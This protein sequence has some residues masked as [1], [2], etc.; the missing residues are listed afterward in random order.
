MENQEILNLKK[1]LSTLE[2]ENKW[3]NDENLKLKKAITSIHNSKSWKITTPLRFVMQKISR[4]KWFLAQL[5][6]I[7]CFQKYTFNFNSINSKFQTSKKLASGRFEII[8][9]SKE[10]MAV[11]FHYEYAPEGKGVYLISIAPRSETQRQIINLP[12]GVHSIR[13]EPLNPKQDKISFSSFEL[14]QVGMLQFI[15]YKLTAKYGEHWLTIANL[16]SIIKT[17]T[18]KIK[19]H[20][21]RGLLNSSSGNDNYPL[22]VQQFDTLDDTE[23]RKQLVEQANF[24]YRPLVSIIMPT[25]NTPAEF[26]IKAI[27]SVIKQTYANW[28]L[29]IAD[30]CSTT[31]ETKDAIKELVKKDAR[32]KAT[33]REKNGHI[34]AASN[35]A[36]ELAN[37]EFLGFLDHDDE[38][39]PQALFEV[40][41]KLNIK[42]QEINLIYSDEDKINVQGQRLNPYFKPDFNYELFLQQNYLCHFCV[43]RKSVIDSVQGLRLGL[44]GAQDWDLLLRVIEKIDRQTIKHIP[45]ILYHWRII[46]TSTASSTSAKPYVMEVQKKAVSEHLERRQ[47]KA[48]VSIIEDISQLKVTYSLPE[49][50]PLIS[51][52]IPTKDRADLLEMSVGSIL[53]QSTYQNFEI[54]IVDNN[55]SK[56]ET[57]AYFN[58]IQA[59]DS[60]VRVVKDEGD[61]NYSRI[62]N[63]AVAVANGEI[64]GLVNNDIQVITANWLEEMLGLLLQEDVGAVGARL[65]WPNNLL[66][67]G[68]VV[69]GINSIA[70]HSHKG[71][72]R[73]DV[74]YFNRIILNSEFSAVTAACLLT[75]K[76]L[77]EQVDGLDAY[78]LQVAFNDVDYCLK[79]GSLGYRIIYS[80]YAEMYHHESASRGY[81][82][83]PEKVARAE[84]E[85]SYMQNKWKELLFNDPCYNPNLTLIT[86]DFG[87]S[88]PPRNK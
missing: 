36:I 30:D 80:A 76:S 59:Q 25:Y 28:E 52:I 20:G 74:G 8:T 69:L 39:A 61:F 22:W 66:Q 32:I 53:S 64:I 68:G 44:E 43:I 67:H 15:N 16:Q 40:V 31:I 12:A 3:L 21:I 55:S 46:P 10:M 65:Y 11:N 33:F 4:P 73:G 82:D 88:F 23:K 54:I 19:L 71:R 27:Q 9:T 62:N 6:Q 35:S 5:G 60:R 84:K 72:I 2:L 87:L 13:I 78:N 51:L 29:C 49:K 56:E 77:F 83:N 58:K 79:L 47:I 75:K 63:S 70:G 81:E 7:Y 86:E 26:L 48:E 18:K 41:R 14:V 1:K 38:L 34:S 50:L 17:I 85:I 37:G 57:W 42:D 24:D 45:K